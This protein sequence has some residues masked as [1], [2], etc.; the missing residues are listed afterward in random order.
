MSLYVWGIGCGAGELIEKGLGMESITA[1]VESSP[2]MDS[3]LGKAVLAPGQIDVPACELIIVT[4]R[5]AQ[6]VL[7]HCLS[8][9]IAREKLFFLKNSCTLTD[10]NRQSAASDVLGKE[11]YEAIMP[12]QRLISEPDCLKGGVEKRGD[13]VRLAQLELICRRLSPVPGA[14]AEL[15][16]FRGEFASRINALLPDRKLYLFDSFQGFDE[17]S[18][19]G[20]AFHAAHE[21][22]CAQAVL[23]R[24]PLPGNVEIR[25]GFFPKTLKGLEERFCLVSLDV[26]FYD[27]TLEGLR[28]FWPRLNSGGYVLLHDWGNTR[29]EG[30]ARALGQYEKELGTS[31]PAVPLCD[32]GSSLVL[33]KP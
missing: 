20:E 13:Y 2:T 9:G 23:D 5:Y 10:L 3:F 6:E 8:L 7:E 33:V 28:Y 32:I 12:H 29:L 17:N 1:F 24:M 19:A 11:L 26:D 27:A 18:G 30:V 16:V 25:A 4:T 21:N 22:T 31:I 14:A 15:G